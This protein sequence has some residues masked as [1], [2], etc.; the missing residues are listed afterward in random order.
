MNR[1]LVHHS[2]KGP[3]GVPDRVPD[4][5]SGVWHLLLGHPDEA[6]KDYPSFQEEG[7]AAPN[8][9]ERTVSGNKETWRQQ[10]A[11][12]APLG[13]LHERTPQEGEDRE[14]LIDRK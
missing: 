7:V 13:L 3:T 14:F 4:C 11:T 10:G 12:R 2:A 9:A 8:T 6:W 5:P 1:R